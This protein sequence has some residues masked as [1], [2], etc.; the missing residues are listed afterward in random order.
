MGLTGR[1]DVFVSLFRTPSRDVLPYARNV[2]HTK[3]RLDITR[4]GRLHRPRGV[5]FHAAV[6]QFLEAVS[7]GAP[8]ISNTRPHIVV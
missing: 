3:I 6:D 8:R 4:G 7:T 5:L 2:L 1:I